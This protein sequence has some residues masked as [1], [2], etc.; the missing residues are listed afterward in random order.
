MTRPAV[1]LVF[2]AAM[3]LALLA[4]AQVAESVLLGVVA[5]D[6][7]AGLPGVSVIGRDEATGISRTMSTV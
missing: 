6:Q 5:D 2:A 1:L 7:G 4:E 3:I